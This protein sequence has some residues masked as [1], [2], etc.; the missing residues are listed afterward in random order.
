MW[1]I[2]SHSLSLIVDFKAFYFSM[3]VVRIPSKQI[4][5]LTNSYDCEYELVKIHWSSDQYSI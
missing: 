2:F 4:G 3:L 5:Y 1:V